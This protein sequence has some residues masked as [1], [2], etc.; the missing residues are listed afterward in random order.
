M[1]YSKLLAVTA[2]TPFVVLEGDNYVIDPKIDRK[3]TK[4]VTPSKKTVTPSKKTEST[5]KLERPSQLYN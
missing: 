1:F 3:Y 2:V 4:L 5:D